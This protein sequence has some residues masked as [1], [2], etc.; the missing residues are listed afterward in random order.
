MG[1]DPEQ[2]AIARTYL[3]RVES[4]LPSPTA[5]AYITQR[6]RELDQREAELETT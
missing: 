2:I 5:A 4:M 3:T 6:R 1:D